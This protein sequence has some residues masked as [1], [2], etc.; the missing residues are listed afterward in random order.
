[1]SASI[2][3][4]D[5]GPSKDEPLKYAP[6]KARHPDPDQRPAGPAAGLSPKADAAPKGDAVSKGDAVP[7][8]RP[9]G[10]TP[11]ESIEPPWRRSRHRGGGGFVGDVAIAE[12]RTKLALAP[13]RLPEPPPPSSQGSKLVWA[14]RIAGVVVVA[15]VGFVGYRWGSS[16]SASHFQL[17][18]PASHSRVASDRTVTDSAR[19]APGATDGVTL[20]N[21]VPAVYPPPQKGSPPPSGGPPS[22]RLSVGVVGALQTDEV[23]RLTIAAVDAGANAVVTIGGLASGSTVSAGKEVAPNLWRL[24]VGE[25]AGATVAPPRGF[26]GIMDLTLELRLADNS[27][28]DR[29]GLHLEWVGKGG[30]AVTNSAVARAQARQH[31]AG[32]I[33]QM[34][35]RG[36][37]LMVNGDIAAARLMYQRAAEA[38]EA[39]AAFALAETYD[40]LVLAKG[41]VP[42]DV[43]LARTWYEKARDLG[44]PVAPERLERLGRLPGDAAP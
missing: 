19:P 13:D 32:E 20:V 35:K 41:G 44:S 23:A 7:R 18:R 6:K 34:V 26:A 9:P 12:L 30:P 40:P 5:P 2:R 22:K 29:K 14:G 15:I 10:S 38:G 28:A 31:D 8:G 11:P 24:F 39:V 36:G 27:V 1:M 42:P 43:G 16:P 17:L 3:E 21:T 25:L 4:P 37:E 33:A